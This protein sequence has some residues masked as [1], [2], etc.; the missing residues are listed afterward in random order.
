VGT[1]L[2]NGRMWEWDIFEK[3][4]RMCSKTSLL[5][6]DQ[7]IPT[8]NYRGHDGRKNRTWYT[9]N[10]LLTNTVFSP[11]LLI[12]YDLEKFSALFY[13]NPYCQMLNRDYLHNKYCSA[14]VSSYLMQ[15]W[16]SILRATRYIITW[17]I[18]SRGKHVR[19]LH[20]TG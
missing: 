3:H 1:K 2:T 16:I 18:I 11:Y 17:V 19:K 6:R 20:A 12:S 10:T 4:W 15:P 9:T 5:L 14:S 7:A 13:V 8:M